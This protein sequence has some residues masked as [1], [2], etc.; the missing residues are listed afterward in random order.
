MADN[1]N[2]NPAP[3]LPEPT[4]VSQPMWKAANEGKLFL[5]FDPISGKPQFWPRPVNVQ[6]GKADYEW[7]EVSGKGTLYAWTLVQVPAPGFDDRVP[8]V[9]GSVDLAEGGRVV[10][11][12]VNAEVEQL[13]PGLAVRVVWER[14]SEEIN[15]YSFEPDQ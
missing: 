3:P 4:L 7:R 1:K 12:M 13:T 10:A 2:E 11:Q 15:I 5:Q 9:L 8:Y 6:N 14:R